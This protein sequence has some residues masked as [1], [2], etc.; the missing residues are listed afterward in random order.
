MTHLVEKG[1]CRQAL[2]PTLMFAGEFL[3]SELFL[4]NP[5]FFVAAAWAALAFWRTS[6]HNPRLIFF[7]SMGAPLFL[8]YFFYSFKSRILPNRIAPAVLP[9]FCLM[10]IYWDTGL[11]LGATRIKVWLATGLILGSTLV[12]VACDTNLVSKVTKYRL[13]V[14]YDPL[15]RVHGWDDT[16][17]LVGDVRNELLSEGKPG[18]HYRRPLWDGG[19]GFILPA[20][21]KGPGAG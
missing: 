10:V 13:P 14:K 1:W 19:P 12:I 16:A 7:F 17:K 5:I 2:V 9:L 18:F 6:R 4:L 11:R 21:S 3:G 20:G 15:R 8:A